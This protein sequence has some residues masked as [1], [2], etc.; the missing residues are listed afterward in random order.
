MV[1]KIYGELN[2]IRRILSFLIICI[3]GLSL[4]GSCAKPERQFAAAELLDLGEKYLLEMNYEQALVQF[5]KV[6]EIE[7]MNPRGYTGAADAYIGFGDIDKATEILRQ[8]QE[9]LP[10]EISITTML[11]ELAET[12]TQTENSQLEPN[13]PLW[14]SFADEQK[15]MLNRLEQAAETFNYETVYEIMTS[16]DFLELYSQLGID[17]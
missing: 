9:R 3:L 2:K 11:N 5:L 4:L 14:D 10:D 15:T 13:T 17:N 16:S 12:S 6:I 8:G 1:N 7:P